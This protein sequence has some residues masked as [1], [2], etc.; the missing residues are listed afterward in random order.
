[1]RRS[2]A[3]PASLIAL[4]LLLVG[5]PPLIAQGPPPTPTSL[6]DPRLADLRTASVAWENRE[7]PR[8]QV[9]DVVCLVPDVPTFLEAIS[10]WDQGHFFP[11]LLDDPETVLKFLRAFRPACVVRYPRRGRA[12]P[13][14]RLWAEAVAAV[15]RSW[16][17]ATAGGTTGPPGDLIPKALGPTPPAVVLSSPGSPMLA[18]AVALA[19]GRF[20][21]L[22]RWDPPK[23]VGDVLSAE[24]A[25][26]Y[27]REI[28]HLVAG[29]CDDYAR[30]GDDCDFVTLAG[31]YPYRYEAVKGTTIAGL[32]AEGTA[33]FDDRIA[34]VAD[35]QRRWAFTGR[36]LG[37]PVAS[38]YRAMCSLFLQPRA[39]LLFNTYGE[40]GD[41]WSLYAMRDATR[42][43]QERLK[44]EHRAGPEEADLAGWH[45]V[46]DPVNRFD[47][48]LLNS[49]GNRDQF[50]VVGGSGHSGDVPFSEPAAVL[51]IHSHSAAEPNDI[52]TLAGR[53]LA[54]GVFLYFGSMNEPYLQSFRPPRLVADLIVEGIP[55]GA[56]VRQSWGEFFGNPWR[57]LY[58]GDPQF[59]LRPRAS[60][61]GRADWPE[62]RSWPSYTES[63]RPPAGSAED[64]RLGWAVRTAIVR[65]S[66][67]GGP[68]RADLIE[69]LLVIR[70]ERLSRTFRPV[71]ESL[72]VDVLTQA[73]RGPELR[74]RL[75]A[76]PPTE[77]SPSWRR[78]LET[79]TVTDL[80]H[81]LAEKDLPRAAALWD[82]LVRSESALDLKGEVTSRVSALADTPA[83]RAQWR[84][85]LQ[86]TLR[87]VNDAPI[88][89][90]IRQEL[91]RLEARRD[92]DHETTRWD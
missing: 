80:Y 89:E 44:V 46:F 12:I 66:R 84:A 8:R 11:I 85:Q 77:R 75:D 82:R 22:L 58:L 91:T 20:Q 21:P 67:R 65:A 79:S 73:S 40:E 51:A 68:F 15:G 60:D 17:A 48:V 6:F 61:A 37:D 54:N 81:A 38:V 92:N 39:A 64:D 78:W 57:L 13:P 87:R 7:G 2:A 53:W 19:A 90:R 62:I 42:R 24:E 59:R 33:A 10:T 18:G 63:P 55:F 32:S 27:A 83:R 34:R 26:V 70:R 16:S 25:E 5:P 3:R 52:E 50:S 30:L 71:Y 45:R 35:T 31:D 56:A 4:V 76:I 1:M 86:A 49:S 41:P 47:L 14:E 36:L 74:A 28:E 69:E 88:A 23:H 29:T 9:V 72:L 43:L